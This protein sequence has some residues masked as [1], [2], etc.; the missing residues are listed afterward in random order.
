MPPVDHPL[1]RGAA[2]RDARRRRLP[3]PGARGRDGARRVQRRRG[4]GA[5]ARDEPQAQRRRRSRRSASRF[6]EGAR[7][8]GRRARS[9]RT[10]STTS[11]SASPASASRS[12]TRPR[13]ALLAY[14]SAWLRHHYPAEFLCALLNA[15]PMGFYPPAALV[16]D[17]QRRGVEVRP[18]DVN[19]SAAQCAIEDECACGSGSSTCARSARRRREAV[20]A[21]RERAAVR[22]RR[23][24]SR[25]GRALD[26]GAARGAR[27]LGRLRLARRPRRA[28]LWELGLVPRSQS[29]PGS[30]GEERQL[31]LPLDPTAETPDAARADAWERMLADYRHDEPL[32][33]RR[34][35]WSCCA[36]TCP[37]GDLSSRELRQAPDGGTVA[38]A[39][40]A[41]ARQRPATANG[42]VFMLLEDELGQVN[43]IVPPPVYERFRALVRGEPL[44]LARGTLRAGRPQPERRSS[45]SSSRSARSPARSPATPTSSARCRR[46]TTSATASATPTHLRRVGLNP[47]PS[48]STVAGFGARIVPNRASAPALPTQ[49]RASSPRA[50]S[51]S[52]RADG[53]APIRDY[54]L[55]GDGR[56][57][58]SSPGTGRSTGSACPTSTRRRSSRACST[59]G[60]AARSG[61]S[62]PS[63]SR[64]SG[65]TSRLERARDDLH[66]RE[67][68]ACA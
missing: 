58:R 17:A 57:R 25:S 41:V 12:R 5:A 8:E 26:R 4:R 21:E 3:G 24:S 28:L 43:L 35:R 56:H 19:R 7:G 23:A 46:R 13:S 42:V 52:D 48:R 62:R 59:P 16:R 55:V 1:L 27:R 36:R 66:D 34:T 2:A 39:G 33:R 61:S 65:A 49:R 9:W 40:M 60:A 32:G 22:G 53:Y 64:P 31:A 15:Q 18:P 14:Q 67:G 50:E 6:V 30:G 11:S 51:R 47:P 44:L 37:R 20:V 45:A 38:V 63:R 54:A 10:R 29:V 68:R